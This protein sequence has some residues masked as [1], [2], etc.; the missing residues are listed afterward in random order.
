MDIEYVFVWAHWS[1][2]IYAE[3]SAV[4]ASIP[5]SVNA[6]RNINRGVAAGRNAHL[7]GNFAAIV[8]D[9]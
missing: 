6:L 5:D 3:T 8:G 1:V 7:H 9:F 4:A 2:W